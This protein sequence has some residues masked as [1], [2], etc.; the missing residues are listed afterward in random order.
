MFLSFAGG[1]KE[2]TAEYNDNKK[3]QIHAGFWRG[4]GLMGLET[5]RNLCFFYTI[6]FL[7]LPSGCFHLIPSQFSFLA[8]RN[9]P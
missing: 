8:A 5:R 7:C 9:Y 1:K 6:I 3:A 2:L 4:K